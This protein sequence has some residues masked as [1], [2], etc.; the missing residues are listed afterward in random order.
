MRSKLGYSAGSPFNSN[1][2]NLIQHNPTSSLNSKSKSIEMRNTY[3]PLIALDGNRGT[4]L[5]FPGSQYQNRQLPT[6]RKFQSGGPI[7]QEVPMETLSMLEPVLLQKHLSTLKKAQKDEFMRK[8]TPLDQSMRRAALMQML[9]KY[10]E[11]ISALNEGLNPTPQLIEQGGNSYQTGGAVDPF[12][13]FQERATKSIMGVSNTPTSINY[14]VL[15]KSDKESIKSVQKRLKDQG[16]YTGSI[17]GVAGPLTKRAVESFN[18]SGVYHRTLPEA[19]VTTLSKQTEAQIAKNKEQ[20][21]FNSNYIIVND[22]QNTMHIVSPDHTILK[23]MPAITGRDSGDVNTAP[24][25]KSWVK[26]NKGKSFSDYLTFLDESKQKITPSGT[27]FVSKKDRNPSD[28]KDIRGKVKQFLFDNG[29]IQDEDYN[30]RG[31][32][33]KNYGNG[34]LGLEDIGGTGIGQAI[35]GTGNKSRLAKLR[36]GEGSRDVSAG[37]I[38]IDG[39]EYCFDDVDMGSMVQVLPEDGTVLD[40]GVAK[41]S[42]LKKSD[43]KLARSLYKVKDELTPSDSFDEDV[44]AVVGIINNESGGGKSIRYKAENLLQTLGLLGESNSLGPGQVKMASLNNTTK[45][46]LSELGVNSIEDLRD[47]KKAPIAV[48]EKLQ[49][50][51]KAGAA[52]SFDLL[53]RY[54]GSSADSRETA[55]KNVRDYVSRVEKVQGRIKQNGG[56]VFA[57]I[58]PRNQVLADRFNRKLDEGFKTKS[59]SPT[60][61][62][63]K[64]TALDSTFNT[65]YNGI[66]LNPQDSLFLNPFGLQTGAPVEYNPLLQVPLQPPYPVMEASTPEGG[67]SKSKS[68]DR[69]REKKMGGESSNGLSR[70]KA[71]K[72]L[73]DGTIHG[74]KITDRQRRYFAAVAYGDKKQN[75]GE[76]DNQSSWQPIMPFEGWRTD[77]IT[78]NRPTKSN[79]ID[80]TAFPQGVVNGPKKESVNPIKAKKNSRP[81]MFLA[82]HGQAG[83]RSKWEPALNQSQSNQST[84]TSMGFMYQQPPVMQRSTS[85]PTPVS[86]TTAII[87][88]VTRDPI[89]SLTTTSRAPGRALMSGIAPTPWFAVDPAPS[90]TMTAD[91]FV[92]PIAPFYQQT[93]DRSFTPPAGVS[94]RFQFVSNDRRGRWENVYDPVTR[95]QY[96]RD[97]QTGEYWVGFSANPDR[98][99]QD[100]MW[101]QS[102]NR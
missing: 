88:S 73:H 58:D 1:A 68:K 33:F 54:M 14:E 31:K 50:L 29:I 41:F 64:L 59:G 100:A 81:S 83:D 48:Y 24:P 89:Y 67:S 92:Q 4:S 53:R 17:D 18:D 23:T 77:E 82:P 60:G 6:Q 86:N 32:R 7:T 55:P 39:I 30:I 63:P 79:T 75:G 46:K 71:E 12:F 10:P 5:L 98:S 44:A 80:L 78:S 22:S 56:D 84:G 69:F 11:V 16:L 101:L 99:Q 87:A 51:K 28:P 38:N 61:V 91:N 35:H 45:Q 37:C 15:K 90:P 72:M 102:L 65:S 8:Y 47:L 93:K 85:A 76:T 40:A 94:D 95:N 9:G 20:G 43:N 97:T 52:D 21:N 74:K 34:L 25:F 27:F 49:E 66:G 42:K 13:P 57:A 62:N 2:L 19:E 96:R 3:K 36:S 26:E 70:A